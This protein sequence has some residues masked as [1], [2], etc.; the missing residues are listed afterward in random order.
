[1]GFQESKYG[2]RRHLVPQVPQSPNI[3]SCN[4]FG[5]NPAG[6]KVQR[7]SN[8]HLW[9]SD[10]P[11]RIYLVKSSK[12]SQKELQTSNYNLRGCVYSTT[13]GRYALLLRSVDD[14]QL[15]ITTSISIL[16]CTRTSTSL[17]WTPPTMALAVECAPPSLSWRERESTLH[18]GGRITPHYLRKEATTGRDRYIFVGHHIRNTYILA[19]L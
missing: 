5:S 6:Q 7:P 14:F 12:G 15:P 3:R 19:G 8:Q 10:S 11:L 17:F 4:S 18:F 9:A 2:Y 13:S 16:Q 1:M